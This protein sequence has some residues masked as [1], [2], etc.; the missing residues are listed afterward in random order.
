M[1][2]PPLDVDVDAFA[3][4]LDALR[5]EL[6]AQLGPEDYQHLRKMLRWSSACTAA[7]YAT[8]WI[9]PNP[10]SAALL[11][12]G[13]FTR[14]LPSAHHILHGAFDKIPGV[15]KRHTAKHFGRGWRRYVDWLDWFEPAGWAKHH[16]FTHHYRVNEAAD[17]DN[18]ERNH[19]GLRQSDLP[20]P[21]RYLAFALTAG[22]WRVAMYGPMLQFYERDLGRLGM[23]DP[24]FPDWRVWAPFATPGRKV[25]RR[26]WLPNA[27]VRFGLIPLLFAPLG[28]W[29]SF[30]LFVNSIVADI[31]L[32]VHG[33]ACAMA[34]HSGDDLYQFDESVRGRA[35]F[36]LHQLLATADMTS[37]GDLHD[38]LHGFLNY[39]VAHHLWPDMTMLQLRRATPRI[40]EICERHGV[41]YISEP[42]HKRV[43]RLV[44]I[45][46]GA[47]TMPRWPARDP[48]AA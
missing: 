47:T 8:A 40:K 43:K 48:E 1:T 38:F 17:L 9:A 41:P 37:G 6:R 4:D 45:A 28:P 3:R 10:V 24:W 22:M 14:W 27:G 42:L 35:D 20:T 16:N 30:S 34:S 23:S 33:Y 2:A 5:N 12:L 25:W 39:Q 13:Q 32:S 31:L 21:L 26:S 19:Q 44:D 36:Y 18:V 29:A 11:G 46:T 7:G 15:P